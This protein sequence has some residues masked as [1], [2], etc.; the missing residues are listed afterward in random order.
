RALATQVVAWLSPKPIEPVS[1][2]LRLAALAIESDTPPPVD[3]VVTSSWEAMRLGDR[4]LGERLAQSALD[5]SDG[6]TARLPLA[7]ALSWLGRGPDADRVLTPV[8]PAT[9]SEG[10]LTGWPQTKRASQFWMLDQPE[11]AVDF[12][13]AMRDRIS[14]PAAVATIDPLVA[15]FAVN[16]GAPL[17]ALEIAAK[18]LDSPASED[19]A[20]A[21]AAATATLSSARMGKFDD[22]GPL[23]E[24]G[25]A[26]PHPGLLRF[27]IGLGEITTLVMTK[28]VLHAQRL[29]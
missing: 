21:W 13:Y 1:A 9:P 20:V 22:V 10:D 16:A 4:L 26:T 7:H 23:A 6:L 8:D 28:S 18:V 17:R 5:R 3:D 24:R 19:L 12:L 15:T 11:A 29:A 27:V 2:K 14:E 25:L